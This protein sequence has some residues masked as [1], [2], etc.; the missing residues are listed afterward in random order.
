MISRSEV[1]KELQISAPSA[2]RLLQKMLEEKLIE[3]NGNGR[4]TKYCLKKD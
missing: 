1:I 3:K 4:S 2:S